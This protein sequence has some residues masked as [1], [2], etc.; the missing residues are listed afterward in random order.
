MQMSTTHSS[1]DQYYISH[2]TISYRAAAAPIP[3]VHR[4]GPMT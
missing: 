3:E 1:F 2:N 4:E